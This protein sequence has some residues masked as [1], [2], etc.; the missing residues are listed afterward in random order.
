M[1]SCHVGAVRGKRPACFFTAV[2]LLWPFHARVLSS[3]RLCVLTPVDSHDVV[4]VGAGVAGCS[5]RSPVCRR[6]PGHS[7]SIGLATLPS[8]AAAA[9]PPQ[10]PKTRLP[11]LTSSSQ[12]PCASHLSPGIVR[13]TDL[14]SGRSQSYQ[15]DYLNV[16]RAFFDAWLLDLARER[17]EVLENT[18][19]VGW[20]AGR[21]LL[22]SG[23]RTYEVRARYV[24]GADGANSSVRRRGF[25]TRPG[26]PV[27]LA[28]QARVSCSEPPHAH[29]VLFSRALTSFYAWAIPKGDGVLIGSAFGDRK[30]ASIIP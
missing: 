13:V 4:I 18:S 25:A 21:V 11:S 12:L 16:D 9:R 20:D 27:L 22:R 26:P 3:I 15:R 8:R 23:R 24:I 14:D 1:V 5:D 28:L 2:P 30:C 17:A 29:E 19:F 10:T 7:L 6:V